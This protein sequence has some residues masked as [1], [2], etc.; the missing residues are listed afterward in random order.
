M[1]KRRLQKNQKKVKLTEHTAGPR[2]TGEHTIDFG[3]ANEQTTRLIALVGLAFL[4]GFLA[5]SRKQP[6]AQQCS[7]PTKLTPPSFGEFSLY[8]I[9]SKKDRQ[10]VIGDLAEEFAEVLVKFGSRKAR[11]WYYKQVITSA[12]P[13]IR[14]GF[15][16]GLLA[17]AG[18]WI[19]RRI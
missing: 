16:I 3:S 6:S 18:E 12:W 2:Q 8:M 11:I 19:R 1:T 13:L 9:L 14:K 4:L 10:Y 5:H 7:V 17:W 15:R